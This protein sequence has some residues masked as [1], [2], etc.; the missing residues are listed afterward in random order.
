[1]VDAL[2]HGLPELLLLLVLDGLED[3]PLDQLLLLGLLVV[4]A[5]LLVV[6]LYVLLNLMFYFSLM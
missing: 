5:D 3:D 6:V 4:I 1:M 2:L